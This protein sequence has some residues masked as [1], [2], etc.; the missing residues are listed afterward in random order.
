MVKSGADLS[1]PETHARILKEPLP[2]MSEVALEEDKAPSGSADDYLFSKA[3]ILQDSPVSFMKFLSMRAPRSSGSGSSSASSSSQNMPNSLIVAAQTDGAVRLFTPNGDLVLSFNA[4]HEHPV[5]SLAVSPTQDEYFVVTADAA[6]VIRVHKITVR[7]KRLTQDQ[8]K[9]RR[10]STDEKVSQFLGTPVDVTYTLSQKMEVPPGDDG[11][12]VRVTTLATGS[13]SGNKYF[14]AGDSSGQLST[15]SRNGTF[16]AKLDLGVTR[17]Q[18]V[19]GLY[20]H[21]S[22]LIFYSGTEWGFVNLEKHHVQRM[23]CL[24]F[25]GR[26][27]SMVF[28][29]QQGSR[30]LVGDEDGT[31]WVLNVKEKKN[32][33]VEHRYPKGATH[34]P[35]KLASVKGFAIALE[36]AERGVDAASV[37]ALNM[38]HVGK[39]H[40]TSPVVWRKGRQVVRDW[41][42]H[43]RQQSGDMLAF[44]SGDGLEI[45]VMEL[46]MS[47]YTPPSTGGDFGNFKMPVIA[48]AIFLVLGY[49]YMKGKGGGGKGGKSRSKFGDLGDNFGS[50][51]N[52]KKGGKLGGLGGLGGLKNRRR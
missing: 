37:L 30:L 19:V 26:I 40:A 49:Q 1:L 18:Q 47:V 41:A 17:G 15:F 48:V 42:V 3:T 36:N 21:L 39:K 13:Q 2:M 46:L 29:S 32:C 4:G 16:K 45:E 6:G 38:S 24:P 23:E 33:K 7:Q 20:A 35:I 51:L 8:K 44:L 50:L 28:D 34:A 11:E 9:G 12:P 27:T 14:V 31:V 22:N 25:E 43:K 52:K 5:T 10:N